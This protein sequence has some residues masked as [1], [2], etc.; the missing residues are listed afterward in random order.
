MEKKDHILTLKDS[1]CCLYCSPDGAVD[2][3]W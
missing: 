2:S 1:I 3:E